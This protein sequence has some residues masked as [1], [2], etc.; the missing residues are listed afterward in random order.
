VVGQSV[1]LRGPLRG[2]LDLRAGAEIMLMNCSFF[3]FIV[4][5]SLESSGILN[6]SPCCF[7]RIIKAEV[8][9]Y[10]L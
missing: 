10:L 9:K 8:K 1:G 7:L 3:L 4:N 2:V 6:N 5:Q